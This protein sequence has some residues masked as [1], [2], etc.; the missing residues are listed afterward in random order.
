[1]ADF[2][3]EYRKCGGFPDSGSPKGI[4]RCKPSSR[5]SSLVSPARLQQAFFIIFRAELGMEEYVVDGRH[6]A[7]TEALVSWNSS[8][9]QTEPGSGTSKAVD[10][11]SA[12]LPLAQL[13]K[14]ANLAAANASEE[15][16]IKAMMVQSCQEYDPIN[17]MKR[18][19]GPPPSS[20]PCRYYGKP[21]HYRRNCPTSGDKN[22][23]PA[24]R[25]RRSTGIP[26][27]FLIELKD[28]NTKGA[29]LTK[30]GKYAI[31]IINA[32]AYA[33]GKKEKPPFVP[34]ELP[35]SSSSSDALPDELLCLI[36]K[37]AMTDAAVTPCCG[38]SY[39]DECIRTALLA[40]EEHTCPAC[41]QAGVSPDDLA[42]NKFLRQAVNNF[43]TGAGYTTRFLQKI[44]QQ[45]QQPP[46]LLPV[47]PPGPFHSIM[48]AAA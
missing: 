37:D 35:S 22:F 42:A 43:K 38:S 36:C 4:E 9:S 11:S 12:S 7:L 39:C 24:P 17:Y 34:E 28:P 41:H 27:S 21:G 18:P 47:A 29:M 44:Q 20:F 32:E 26:R 13:I 19:V 23:V 45:Q 33:R 15:D 31:P 2:W 8:R 5:G 1:M 3:N 6:L 10:D 40:S 16:K 48:S 25:M 14:T 30:T 46:P